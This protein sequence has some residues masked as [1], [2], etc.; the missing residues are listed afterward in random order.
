M[1]DK[2]N[3]LLASIQ[4]FPYGLKNSLFDI[5][6]DSNRDNSLVPFIKLKKYFLNH[7]V[8][9]N[10]S[11]L[12]IDREVDFE[13]HFNVYAQSNVNIP[14]Y[15]LALETPLI[16]PKNWDQKELSKYRKI[17]CWGQNIYPIDKYVPLYYPQTLVIPEVNGFSGRDRFCCLIAG[18][19]K[20]AQYDPRELY[21]ERVKTIRWFEKN[22][23]KDFDLYGYNWHKLPPKQ[24][25][26]FLLTK[27]ENRILSK[28]YEL[29]KLNPFPSYRGK[30][31]SKRDI[32]SQYRF[33]ICYENARD[34]SGYITEKIFDCFFAGNV[35]VY[36]GADNVSKIIPS[37]CYIDR[38]EFKDT[39]DVYKFLKTMDET[40]Y[41]KYQQ[42]IREFLLSDM[43]KPFSDDVFAE[44]IVSTITE[45]IKLLNK[46]GKLE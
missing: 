8:E 40:T 25:K 45:D 32:L 14:L 30:I 42:S 44:T 36:W 12:N 24:Q 43:A 13:I 11:D 27:I 41:Q 23:P 1:Q 26:N 3:L 29:I 46:E 18:N 28:L 10:T 38:R 37:N 2:T 19:K 20:V 9:L 39:A 16:H 4:S 35:P 17:F 21:S 7:N 15:L 31:K 6:S 34:F 5:D 33:S 22:A